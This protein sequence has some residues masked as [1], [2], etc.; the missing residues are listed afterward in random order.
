[1][2]GAFFLPRANGFANGAAL[3]VLCRQVGIESVK[4]GISGIQGCAVRLLGLDGRLAAGF[5]AVCPTETG[6]ALLRQSMTLLPCGDGAAVGGHRAMV[7]RERLPQVA[8][9]QLLIT[10]YLVYNADPGVVSQ[11]PTAVALGT[12]I[13]QFGGRGSYVCW[14]QP[15]AE[16]LAAPSAARA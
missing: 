12:H 10:G 3:G 13:G 15:T 14:R 5:W 4:Q 11:D 8:S 2:E 7:C 16:P 9:P 1:M 6:P